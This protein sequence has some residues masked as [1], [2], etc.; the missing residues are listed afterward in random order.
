MLKQSENNTIE[1]LGAAERDEMGVADS[2]RPW[3][4]PQVILGTL[5]QVQAATNSGV[6]GASHVS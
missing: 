5:N 1:A 4:S 3:K 6:D 2:R